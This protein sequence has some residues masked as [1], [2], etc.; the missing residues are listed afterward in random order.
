MKITTEEVLN[1]WQQY[2]LSNRHGM[3]VSVLNFGGIITEITVPD[4]QNK[5]E[6]VVL[7]YKDYAEYENN[8]NYFGAIIGRVAG[9]IENASFTL[10][11]QKY[12]LKKNNG[13]NHLH[14]G[15]EGFH[16]AI[17]DCTTFQTDD[18]VGVV[19][20]HH[21]EDGSGG[22]AGNVDVTVTY[23]LTNDNELLIDYAATTDQ[24]TALT[25]TNHSYFN[26]TGHL[27][28]TIHHHHVTMNADEFVE[29]DQDLIPT[30]RKL[31]VTNT[32]FDFRQGRQL[33]EGIQS[34]SEQNR[35]AS[36][37]Y[38]HYFIFNKEQNNEIIVKEPTSGRIM[39]VTTNQPG[40]VMYTANTLSN[41][42]DLLEGHSK[43]HL[44]VCF[45][46]QGSPASLHHADF[47]SIVLQA[48]E[49]Y[50]KQ[51]IF[52]FGIEQ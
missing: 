17:W 1:K 49:R 52:S 27:S 4:R 19:L 42:L 45:E 40:V 44:G 15:S 23:T 3:R 37:G 51:T 14:G 5:L 9:R 8:P 32:V 30:G 46:T 29:L 24:T 34:E 35:I 36:R 22:Y 20:T 41:D 33:I 7:S 26:L 21:S 38:D 10:N 25:L 31:D 12:T 2:T 43:P 11:E 48:S 16:Q 39:T 47:P 13:L 6:N 28:D 50:D 18:T